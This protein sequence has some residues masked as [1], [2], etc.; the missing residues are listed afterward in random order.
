MYMKP[1]LNDMKHGVIV[2]LIFMKNYEDILIKFGYP[3][4]R[5]LP[6]LP[7]KNSIFNDFNQEMNFMTIGIDVTGA[8]SSTVATISI[9][10]DA[11]LFTYS[12]SCS[13]L[14]HQDVM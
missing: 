6:N 14:Y 9:T 1:Y 3:L 4:F 12:F 7:D 11:A 10:D 8:T 2:G 5:I 13:L